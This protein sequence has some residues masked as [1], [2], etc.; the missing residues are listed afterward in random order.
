MIKTII[1]VP[2]PFGKGFNVTLP[3]GAPRIDLVSSAEIERLASAFADH[4]QADIVN[5]L[6]VHTDADI[7]AA[8]LAHPQ[9]DI[10][11][12]LLDH[13][14]GSIAG[15]LAVHTGAAIAG[16]L[17]NHTLDTQV[18]VGAPVTNNLGHSAVPQLETAAGANVVIAGCISA[19]AGAGVDPAHANGAAPVAHADG[20]NPVAH[21]AGG[22]PVIHAVGGA[23]VAHVAATLA[24]AAV[25]IKVDRDTFTLNA[26]L[27]VGDLLRL[28]YIE[29]GSRM[30]P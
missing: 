9:A 22:A 16:A 10:V 26:A 7:V 30:I 29:E 23:A 21:V 2:G 15:A 24:V 18:A 11:D 20:A 19:H 3:A 27:L 28:S 8:L 14:P 6:A 5:A 13:T 17:A 4:P 25:P 1:W 12:A